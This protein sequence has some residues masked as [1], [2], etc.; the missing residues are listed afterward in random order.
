MNNREKNGTTGTFGLIV[1][2]SFSVVI[3]IFAIIGLIRFAK[4]LDSVTEIKQIGPVVTGMYI[5]GSN[6]FGTE[7]STQI[8]TQEMI[9]LI[10][11]SVPIKKGNIVYSGTSHMNDKYL[12]YS[13]SE[14]YLWK[15]TD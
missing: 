5:S 10:P 8:E 13:K 12:C 14:C 15:K 2:I 7:I 6:V 1:T 4:W 3:S 11:G 9:I